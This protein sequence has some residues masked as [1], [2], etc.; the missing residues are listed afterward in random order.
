LI[1][2][3]D[4]HLVYQSDE[5]PVHAVRGVSI[6]VPS[7][8]FYTLLGPSGCGKTSLIRCIAG[9]ER[10]A[11]GRI[12]LD[13]ETVFL[14][15]RGI[16]VPTY[17]RKLGMVFQSYAIWPHMDVFGNVA[18]PLKYGGVRLAPGESIGSRVDE[19]LALVGLKG[20]ERRPA[21][22]L[23]GGQQQ[24]VALARALASHPKVLLLDEPLSNLDAR[25]RDEMRHEIRGL[26][27]RLAV[28]TLFVTHD[29]L[30]AFTMSDT[31]GVMNAGRLMQ[32]G[33]P[34]AIY[35]SPVT[36]FVANFVGSSNTLQG[37]V[38]DTKGGDGYQGEVDTPVG[39]LVCHLD[40]EMCPG[41]TVAV[42][43]RPESFELFGDGRVSDSASTTPNVL[44]GTV[45]KVVFLGPTYDLGVAVGDVLLEVTIPSR[46]SPSVGDAITLHL[47][48][49]ECYVMRESETAPA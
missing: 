48:P 16:F 18:Y 35:R 33:P 24:R 47:P 3:E 10:P 20:L 41:D 29:Q 2:I 34:S 40:P 14:R 31:V 27:R 21:P 49:R 39:P 7:G 4:L 9:L 30:E 12:E 26:T 5:G 44:H 15:E 13:G 8:Q 37:K 28:T 22:L 38:R 19:A 1:S 46:H 36:P 32:E 6:E 45:R 17:R 23:S 11:S 25:L 43:I 42:L